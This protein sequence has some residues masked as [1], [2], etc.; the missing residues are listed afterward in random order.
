MGKGMQKPNPSDQDQVLKCNDVEK[1]CKWGSNTKKSDW[2]RTRSSRSF[3]PVCMVVLVLIFILLV[4]LTAAHLGPRLP[5]PD[6][7]HVC[8]DAWLGFQGK[9]YYFSE[10]ESNWTTSQESCKALGS[11]LALI[12][13]VDE[14][15]FVMRY[16]GISEHWLGLSREAEEQP[17]TW[18][19]N[20]HL[21]P[22]FQIRGGG[23]C[24]YLNDNGLSSSRCSTE[25]SWV[26]N[27]PELRSP[28][29]GNGT[30]RA[31]NLC[32]SS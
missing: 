27:Q 23:L 21:S 1:D 7:S 15:S 13:T 26:C 20:S 18:V 5:R 10:V 14:L 30:R 29:E 16:K 28:S 2:E 6:F 3:I 24:A 31:Q 11:S 19:N 9:C 12:S 4:A 8:P 22:L 25:R 17:W 32:V